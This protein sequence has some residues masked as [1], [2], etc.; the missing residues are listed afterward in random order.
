MRKHEN[1]TTTKTLKQTNKTPKL[2]ILVT[3]T[4]YGFFFGVLCIKINN[5]N[6]NI[7]H[8]AY[9]NHKYLLNNAIDAA[10]LLCF[11]VQNLYM[12]GISYGKKTESFL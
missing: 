11:L 2:Q 10:F 3:P 5:K 12:F 7:I 6:R 1:E 9:T 8:T 4:V